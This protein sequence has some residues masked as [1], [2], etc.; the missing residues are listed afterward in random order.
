M[1]LESSTLS[2]STY[3][4]SNV[5]SNPLE[6]AYV[7]RCANCGEG[8]VATSFMALRD[9]EQTFSAYRDPGFGNPPEPGALIAQGPLK[10]IYTLI[11]SVAGKGGSVLLVS[12]AQQGAPVD[13]KKRRG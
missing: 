12:A 9:S 11:S 10:E 6:G 8:I 2:E 5:R 1:F 3:C 13:A 7:L 4:R